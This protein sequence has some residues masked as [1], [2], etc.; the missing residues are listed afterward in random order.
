MGGLAE[1]YCAQLPP[2]FS[3]LIVAPAGDAMDGALALARDGAP[4]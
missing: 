1:T 2:R 3:G 4:Q